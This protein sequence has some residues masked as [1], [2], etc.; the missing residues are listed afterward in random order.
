MVLDAKSQTGDATAN[1]GPPAIWSSVR[2][3]HLTTDRGE[4][5]QHHLEDKATAFPTQAS[6]LVARPQR[7]R[8]YAPWCHPQSVSQRLTKNVLRLLSSIREFTAW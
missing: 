3:R 4:L 5:P 8:P 1:E 7:R 2:R 6:S